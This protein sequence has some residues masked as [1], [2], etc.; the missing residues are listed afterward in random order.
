[1]INAS[2]V[3]HES[4]WIPDDV[5]IQSLQV[6]IRRDPFSRPILPWIKNLLMLE[7]IESFSLFDSLVHHRSRFL[8]HFHEG[9]H[10]IKIGNHTV[11][12]DDFNVRGKC[13]NHLFKGSNDALQGH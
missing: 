5:V 11:T 10:V 2:V 8:K 4:T 6:N 13:W 9:P 3:R 7:L 1:M 12:R